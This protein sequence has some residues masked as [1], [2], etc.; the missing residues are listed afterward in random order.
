MFPWPFNFIP[1]APIARRPRKERKEAVA[2]GSQTPTEESKKDEMD[3]SEAA[4]A[5]GTASVTGGNG[6]QKPQGT[7]TSGPQ[8]EFSNNQTN[9]DETRLVSCYIVL[10]LFH[11]FD[12]ILE[13]FFKYY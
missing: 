1:K 11:N 3:G 4:A 13:L 10:L 2:A 12:K 9:A 5:A 6:G 8:V 7:G